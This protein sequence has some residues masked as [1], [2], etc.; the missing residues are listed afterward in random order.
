MLFTLP[1]L[2]IPSKGSS[3]LSILKG[4]LV[5]SNRTPSWLAGIQVD[6][7][8]NSSTETF[9][10]KN[11]ILDLN[12]IQTPVIYDN[13]GTKTIGYNSIKYY[14]ESHVVNNIKLNINNTSTYSFNSVN[15]YDSYLP[16]ISDKNVITSNNNIYYLPF[17]FYESD[18][19]PCGYLNLS[20]SREIYLDYESTKIEQYT[21][22][23]LYIYAKTINFLL[24]TQNSAN[25]KYIT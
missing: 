16:Y 15:L 20:K 14:Q 7:T 23:K 17:S 2:T 13:A 8:F 25:L 18:N 22:I 6:K 5:L 9:L 4:L 10:L 19:Q 11:A 24:I 12:Y 3:K 21:P 1:R